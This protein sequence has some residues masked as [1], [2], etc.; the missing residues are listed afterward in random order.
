MTTSATNAT[1]PRTPVVST[2]PEAHPLVGPSASAVR[3]G[4][5]E[6]LIPQSRQPVTFVVL[7]RAGGQDVQ[8]RGSLSE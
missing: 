8:L 4:F 1:T 2:S 7:L 5:I 6:D 3:D